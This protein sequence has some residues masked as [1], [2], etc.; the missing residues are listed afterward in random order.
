MNFKSDNQRKACFANMS[1]FS[2]S[3]SG[4][5]DRHYL[6]EFVT[7]LSSYDDFDDE[8]LLKAKLPDKP[9]TDEEIATLKAK[10]SQVEH[11]G[12]GKKK[13]YHGSAGFRGRVIGADGLVPPSQIDMPTSKDEKR[14]PGFDDYVFLTTDK[15]LAKTHAERRARHWGDTEYGPIVY[16]VELDEKEVVPDTFDPIMYPDSFKYKGIIPSEKLKRVKKFSEESIAEKHIS[17]RELDKVFYR[18]WQNAVPD[19]DFGFRYKLRTDPFGDKGFYTREE[20]EEIFKKMHE[21]DIISKKT[22]FSKD[23]KFVMPDNI[24]NP[25]DY[26]PINVSVEKFKEYWK[27]NPDNYFEKDAVAL[28]NRYEGV[29][30]EIEGNKKI[31]MP[32]VYAK[33]GAEPG[34]DA[35]DVADGRHR[36]AAI[37]EGGLKEMKIAVPDFQREWFEE[38]LGA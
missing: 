27:K 17:G 36:S 21:D 6:Q 22:K 14:G 11:G 4:T 35:I 8:I 29:K 5:S 34:L 25:Q 19:K 32:E 10:I 28:H 24:E 15:D 20:A 7:D 16:E 26:V 3:S 30:H 38:R 1:R 2:R 31:Y 23:P 33:P 9:R 37:I 13:F 12:S 18:V